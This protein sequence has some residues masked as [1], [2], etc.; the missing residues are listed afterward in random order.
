MMGHHYLHMHSVG[1]GPSLQLEDA[2]TAL[3]AYWKM[4]EMRLCSNASAAVDQGLLVKGS[5]CVERTLLEL[6]QSNWTK[7][8][9]E[10]ASSR[11]ELGS[12]PGPEISDGDSFYPQIEERW[13]RLTISELMA[14]DEALQLRKRDLVAKKKMFSKALDKINLI[15]PNCIAVK[16]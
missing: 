13:G 3:K 8:S 12:I 1:Y 6:A 5:V 4:A 7:S 11:S 16:E 10:H 2:I 14:E 9:S 15:A